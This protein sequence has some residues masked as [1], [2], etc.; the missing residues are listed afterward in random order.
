MVFAIVINIISS[1]KNERTLNKSYGIPTNKERSC[2]TNKAGSLNKYTKIVIL[3][4][5]III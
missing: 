4:I 2:K 3:V 1:K 5:I